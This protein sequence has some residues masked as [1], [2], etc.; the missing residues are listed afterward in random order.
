M[1]TPL[2]TDESPLN[3]PRVRGNPALHGSAVVLTAK[4]PFKSGGMYIDRMFV[5]ATVAAECFCYLFLRTPRVI[6]VL[7]T[8]TQNTSCRLKDERYGRSRREGH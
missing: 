6:H 2:Y 3:A 1:D 4:L 8:A 5:L 7:V